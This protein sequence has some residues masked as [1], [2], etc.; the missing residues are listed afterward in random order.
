MAFGKRI[1]TIAKWVPENTSVAA[2]GTDHAYL[3][4]L[5]AQMG[6]ITFAAAGDIASGPCLA[7]QK[8]IKSFGLEKIVSVRQ[9]DGLE[10]ITAGEIDIIVI[11]GM[12]GTTIIEILQKS[13]E[14]AK[15]AARLILQPMNAARGTAVLVYQERLEAYKIED[16][17]EEGGIIYEIIIMERG[18]D[19]EYPT[20]VLERGPRLLEE[21]HELLPAHL[22][23]C[24]NATVKCLLQ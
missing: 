2:I 18:L 14:I 17:A 4:V 1:E 6:K 19:R 13:S 3:P 15:S 22:Q 9:G 8:T 21:G 16:L 24:W 23:G 7:A 12:G 20:A 10:I 5:L 11:A